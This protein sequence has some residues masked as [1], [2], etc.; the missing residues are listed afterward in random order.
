MRQ[1]GMLTLAGTFMAGCALAQVDDRPPN[2][3]HQQPAFAGQTRAPEIPAEFG[4]IQTTI[5]G[6]LDSPWGM[7][8][9]PD[10]NLLV[11]EKRGNL[12]L[13]SPDGQVSAPIKGLPQVD[14]RGQGGLLDVAIAP[15]F[16]RTRQIWLSYAEPR[17]NRTNGT[18]V[19]TATLNV[20]GNALDNLK[21]IFQQEPAWASDK[22]FG[23][24]LVF[25][26]Q[27]MLFVTTGERSDR[28]PREL[29]QDL[30]THLGKV[31]RIDPQSGAP[32]GAGQ[33]GAL[34]EIW[35]H[36]HRN[37]Q[38]AAIDPATGQLWTVEHGPRGG[39]ELNRPEPGKN[40]GWPVITYGVEYQGGAVGQGLTAQ[41]GME[42]PVYYWDPV[43][44]P[45]GMAFHDG[46]MFPEMRGDILIGGLQAQALVRLQME[47][48]RV[49]G[50]QRLVPGIGRVRDVEV[51]SDGSIYLLIEDSGE[52]V[53]LTRQ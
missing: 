11:T 16:A 26:P 7:A 39:D 52:L 53:R 1:I 32:A 43:I 15:D 47:G 5:T 4:I 12:R 10:G 40:Y 25:D 14:A 41:E 42:Q 31:V 51:A 33:P 22:H 9:L 37:L 24:R 19:A 13:V 20:Q 45:S 34:P 18:A 46:Q 23:S 49:T 44:A 8:E 35:S 27:G 3:P 2:A 29:A 36:G 30:G 48:G 50:E 17:G 6:R 21:V 38:S 28:E